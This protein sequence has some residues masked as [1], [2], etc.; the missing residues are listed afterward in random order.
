MNFTVD[1]RAYAP[2]QDEHGLMQRLK[3]AL[4]RHNL[5]F[6]LGVF[7]LWFAS[8]HSAISKFVQ[9]IDPE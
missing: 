8:T 4:F 6:T 5:M 9:R 3:N 2:H 1:A 7:I